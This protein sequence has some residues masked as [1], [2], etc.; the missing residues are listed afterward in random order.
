MIDLGGVYP[1]VINIY[2]ADGNLVNPATITLTIT[3]PDGTQPAIVVGNPPVL[4]GQFAYQF[5]T[6]QAGRHTV[7]WQTTAPNVAWTDVFDVA[8]AT[9]PAILSLSDMKNILYIDPADTSDDDTI[10]AM[11]MATTAAVEQYKNEIIVPRTITENVNFG[12]I[13]QRG[14]PIRSRVRLMG[15]PLIS[16]TSVMSL[17]GMITWDPANMLPDRNTGLVQVISGP[18]FAGRMVWTYYAG[19][20]IIPYHILEGSKTIFQHIWEGRR[21][22]GGTGSVVGPEE[23]ADYKHATGIP[24]KAYEMLGPPRPAIF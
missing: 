14:W 12:D 4:A 2:D 18:P 13:W 10:R 9:P 20:P 16:V 22:P 17:D 5:I 3:Q 21:G 23:L 1:A 6:T 11:L 8:E 19:Y 24:R 7:R 15:V